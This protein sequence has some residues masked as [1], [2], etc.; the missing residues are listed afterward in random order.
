MSNDKMT[1]KKLKDWCRNKSNELGISPEIIRRN[2]FL[3]KMLELMAQSPYKDNFIL[4]GGFL[5]SSKLGLNNR[6]T[7]DLDTTIKNMKSDQ[8][9]VEKIFDEIIS[10][11]PIDGIKFERK[12]GHT[13]RTYE[14]NQGVELK[15][16]AQVGNSKEPFQMDITSGEEITPPEVEYQHKLMFENKT[17]DFKAYPDEQI[18]ADKL[19]GIMAYQTQNTRM[20]DYYDV[21]ELTK[22]DKSNISYS[23]L[24]S[25]L[26]KTAQ[27]RKVKIEYK[28]ITAIMDEVEGSEQMNR[29]WTAFQRKNSYA[30]G[31][32]FSDTVKSVRKLLTK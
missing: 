32:S 8:K 1:P 31:V 28:N 2:F 9:Y 7:L 10:Q 21:Y 4:K 14:F 20:R 5:I 25:S 12:E 15:F 16:I 26:R 29:L 11:S 30:Q 18:L 13:I 22:L 24:A 6:S 19:I 27:Q 23:T 17:I 3:E